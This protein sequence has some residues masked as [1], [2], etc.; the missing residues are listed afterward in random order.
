MKTIP[1]EKAFE[2]IADA[3]AIITDQGVVIYPS[4]DELKGCDDSEFMYLAWDDDDLNFH[5]LHFNEGDNQEVKIV[6]TSMFLYDTD[7][8][9]D[10]DHTGIQILKTIN[11]EEHIAS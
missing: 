7:A 6:G 3:D 2:I 1:L 4:L 11:I 10:E 8:N 9:D 5:S